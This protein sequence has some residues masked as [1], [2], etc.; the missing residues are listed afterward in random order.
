METSMGTYR[1]E[2]MDLFVSVKDLGW[3]KILSMEGHQ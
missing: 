1:M 2:N 3:P